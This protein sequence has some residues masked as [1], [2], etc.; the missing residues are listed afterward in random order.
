MTDAWGNNTPGGPVP[1]FTPLTD[2][3]KARLTAPVQDSVTVQDEVFMRA[4][5]ADA[6]HEAMQELIRQ[7]DELKR[8]IAF[9]ST[10][11]EDTSAKLA[12]LGGEPVAHHLHLVDG[13]VIPNH[14]GI[15]THYT[16]T[17]TGPNGQ[18][19]T[20]VTRIAAHYPANSPDPSTLFV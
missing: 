8:Q 20:V 13:R 11:S 16:E 10:V 5:A 18:S 4:R 6:Q 19:K 14:D 12:A 1:E 7:N 2:E 3:E 15:G 17:M 9:N